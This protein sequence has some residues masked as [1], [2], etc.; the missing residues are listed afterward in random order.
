[1]ACGQARSTE[2][3]TCRTRVIATIN[4]ILTRGV[5]RGMYLDRRL[6]GILGGAYSRLQFGILNNIYK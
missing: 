4:I 2:P 5:P 1:M 6:R 3:T